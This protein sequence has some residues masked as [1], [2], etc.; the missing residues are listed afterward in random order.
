[1]P[2][3][4]KMRD[5]EGLE[6]AIIEL[7][8]HWP[9]IQE[10]F[11]RENAKYIELINRDSSKIGRILKCHLIIENY[12]D[13]YLSHQNRIENIQI[14]KLSFYQKALMLPTKGSSAAV[15]RPGILEVNKVRNKFG[16]NLNVDIVIS[17]LSAVDQLLKIARP[18]S[19]IE[20]PI[21]MIESF[22]TIACTW[23]IVSP[24]EIEKAL[25]N[26]FKTISVSE[27]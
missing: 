1:M 7:N 2:S 13:N 25:Q 24:P 11:N 18:A 8:K 4:K 5:I 14:L 16:H 20:D 26:I 27:V 3:E 19:K 17:E 12:M 15:V 21:E 10:Y 23:L 9:N 6:E 22:S